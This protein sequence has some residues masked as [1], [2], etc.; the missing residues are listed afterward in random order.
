[1]FT[2]LHRLPRINSWPF[3]GWTKNSN[4]GAMNC[5]ALLSGATLAKL[6]NQ[7]LAAKT[8]RCFVWVFPLFY[9]LFILPRLWLGPIWWKETE[10]VGGW[11]L[12]G[13][14]RK[15]VHAMQS[16]VQVI[17][18]WLQKIGTSGLRNISQRG[19]IS[20][21][22]TQEMKMPIQPCRSSGV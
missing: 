13:A 3:Q 12:L 22:D 17:D 18:F 4:V 8:C 9:S 20:D 15:M 6:S 19:Q 14:L 11:E 10:F 21:H 1:M 16:H 5:K 7:A 2:V